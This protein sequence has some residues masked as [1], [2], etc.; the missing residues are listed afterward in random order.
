M[1]PGV[2]LFP[3]NTMYEG[4]F[5]AASASF[6]VPVANLAMQANLVGGITA[7]DTCTSAS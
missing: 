4:S 6:R 7:E 3:V 1:R 2:A 5:T